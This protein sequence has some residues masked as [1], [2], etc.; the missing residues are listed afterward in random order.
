[1]LIFS[2]VLSAWAIYKA[3]L[4]LLCC[5]RLIGGSDHA[6]AC[7]CTRVSVS[8]NYPVLPQASALW[9][10]SL[11]GP[12]LLSKEPLFALHWLRP[13][14]THFCPAPCKKSSLRQQAIYVWQCCL[15]TSSFYWI[16][17]VWWMTSSVIDPLRHCHIESLY[18]LYIC[19]INELLRS[20]LL[21]LCVCWGFKFVNRFLSDRS[22]CL[23]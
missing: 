3:V 2:A 1:M 18:M 23:V 9:A 19:C 5:T 7:I 14:K 22:S 6:A 12:R 20:F 16:H 13:S 8:F 21:R 10:N 11:W 4:I 15:G 17:S